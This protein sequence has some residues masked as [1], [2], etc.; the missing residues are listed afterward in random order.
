MGGNCRIRVPNEVILKK[1]RGLKQASGDNP[2]V[3][4]KKVQVK[5]PLIVRS[6]K[7]NEVKLEQTFLYDMP[8]RPGT[9]YIIITKR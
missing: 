8:T 6:V 5:N 4:F 3:F 7:L 1:G 2:N 9:K